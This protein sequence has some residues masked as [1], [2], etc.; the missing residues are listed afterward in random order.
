MELPGLIQFF[1]RSHPQEEG[2]EQ[3]LKFLVVQLGIMADLV[4]A[5]RGLVLLVI[6]VAQATHLLQALLRE[7]TE[8][9][10]FSFLRVAQVLVVVVVVQE[11]SALTHQVVKVEMVGLERPLLFLV[12]L[13]PTLEVVLVVLILQL[14]AGQAAQV[15]AVTAE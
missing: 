13:H 15:E 9:M 10:A 11:Q 7:I 4:E 2:A 1:Q 8:A 14:L 12:F 3:V 6:A 5:D